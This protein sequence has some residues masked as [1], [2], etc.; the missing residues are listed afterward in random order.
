[1]HELPRVIIFTGL[2]DELAEPKNAA[3]K[4]NWDLLVDFSTLRLNGQRYLPRANLD[5]KDLKRY[6]DALND[7]SDGVLTWLARC[8]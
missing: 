7:P 4:Q 2:W 5:P 3:V 1:M 8:L 6:N